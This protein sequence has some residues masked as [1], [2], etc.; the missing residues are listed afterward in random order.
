M[1]LFYEVGYSQLNKN[2][3]ELCGD[4]VE[5]TRTRRSTIVTVSDGLGSGVK[6]NIL[7]SLTTKMAATMLKKGSAVDEV[8]E[9][10]VGTLPTCKV[11]KLAYSTFTVAKLD[12]DGSIY[13]AEYDNPPV[14]S[15]SAQ[16]QLDVRF[17]EREVGEK[18]IREARFRAKPGDWLVIV[19]DGVLHAGIGGVWN[20][21]WGWDRVSSY[22]SRLA[23]SGLSADELA[24]DVT[25]LCNRL[26]GA[27]PGDDAT[28]VAI[29][30][31]EPRHLALMVGPPADPKD[32]EIAVQRLLECPGRKVVA[33]GTTGNLVA[34]ALGK[35]ITVDL[36]SCY[37]DVPPTGVI[38]GIDLVTEGML[39]LVK[40]LEHLRKNTSLSRFEGRRDGASRLARALLEADKVHVIVGRAINPAHQSRDVPAALALKSQLIDDIIRELRKRQKRVSVEY[41]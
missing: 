6:A 20:L 19:S 35:P 38:E 11:R 32:D 24:A 33:G 3:E 17:C 31:R 27:M 41:H 34:R 10:L 25:S 36:G 4:S 16:A 1:Q 28:C 12:T 26:Y 39:T 18:T 30:V 8:I 2:N 22:V 9:T 21:G 5:V 29:R 13:I 37:E 7:S 15:G 23:A 40:T 14:M